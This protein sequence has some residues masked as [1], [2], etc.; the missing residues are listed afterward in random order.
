M[1]KLWKIKQSGLM[2]KDVF[3]TPLEVILFFWGVKIFTFS[4]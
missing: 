4:R 3:L 2:K 1:G